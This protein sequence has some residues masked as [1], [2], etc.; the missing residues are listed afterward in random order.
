MTTATEVK[1]QGEQAARSP[2]TRG[3][4]RWGLAAR[5]VM[6]ALVGVLAFRV[7]LLGRGQAPDRQSALKTVADEPFGEVLLVAIAIGLA[8]YALWQLARTL[9]GG[10]LE[11]GDEDEN[12][13]KRVSYFARGVFYGA[14]FVS[15]VLILVGSGGGSG[16]KEDKATAYVLDLP[17]G[18][19]L[20][21]GVGLGFVGAG[22]FNFYRG[23][24]RKFRE[25]LKLI[26]L[27]EAEDKA[28]SAIGAAGFVARGVVF[29]LVGV[30]LV[31]AAYQYDPQ[32]AI[33][34]DGALSKLAHA[35]YGP[36]LLGLTAAGLFAFGL[37]SF[38]EA[39]YREV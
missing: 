36:Y 37:Y 39:R 23:I 27:S 13:F 35:S 22:L 28:Y 18:R 19:W 17:A 10:N 34:L 8:G 5:G 11:G 6:Y 2:W 32:E 4:A 9:L 29:S 24:T 12:V 26:E 3:F 25:K 21:A 31:R 7:A 15:T 33:G 20:V 38:V 16:Q 30:F 14:L 1:Q